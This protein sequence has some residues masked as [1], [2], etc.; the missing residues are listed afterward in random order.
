MPLH[1]SYLSICAQHFCTFK[2]DIPY[3]CS[4]M[5][6]HIVSFVPYLATQDLSVSIATRSQLRQ[7][8]STFA[9]L[10]LALPNRQVFLCS[11]ENNVLISTCWFVALLQSFNFSCLGNSQQQMRGKHRHSEK[12]KSGLAASPPH[13]TICETR[14]R[15]DKKI[16][17]Y[18]SLWL[19]TVIFMH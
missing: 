9:T 13:G 11:I 15:Y 5:I 18:G 6:H 14:V 16:R 1:G 19:I 10:C 7:L 4:C 2:L 3:V 12:S 17:K 8:N